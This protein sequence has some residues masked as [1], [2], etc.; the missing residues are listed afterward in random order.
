MV[1]SRYEEGK[2]WSPLEVSDVKAFSLMPA[3]AVLHYGQAVF[4]GMK[5]RRNPE[6]AVTVFRGEQ[7]AARLR[8]SA[9]RLVMP[10]ISDEMFLKALHLFLQKDG[11]LTPE[12]SG[13]G[14][15]LRPYLFAEEAFLGV[16]PAHSYIFAIIGSPMD[17]Y[18]SADEGF[19]KL[20]IA[21]S[22]RAAPGGTGDVKAADAKE[23]KYIEEAGA[24]NVMFVKKDGSVV[25]PPLNG[26]I[27]P[28]ITRDSILTLG[29]DL[30]IEMKEEALAIDEVFAAGRAGEI[31][32][33][34][35]SG[36]AVGIIPIGELTRKN[37]DGQIETVHFKGAGQSFPVATR[38]GK[39]LVDIQEGRAEDKHGWVKAY[40]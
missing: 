10:E 29:R 13:S 28:G 21:D 37:S 40:A 39:A 18:F 34:F 17:A 36:T 27:L 31:V 38:L 12:E 8:H 16:R 6:G 22:A 30:G 23:Q 11:H 7:N 20:W 19:L 2:G 1:W 26:S 14:L 24:M 5:A 25:T 9:R 35:S 4:E 33:A 3:A 32:E 15:Y